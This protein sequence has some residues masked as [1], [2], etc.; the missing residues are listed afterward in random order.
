MALGREPLDRPR[1]VA[2][3]LAVAGMV[4]VVA[5][6]LDPAAGIRVDA[7]GFGLALAAAMSQAGFVVISRTGYRAVPA[8]QAM[9]VV[10]ATTLVC[11]VVLARRHRAAGATLTYPLRDPS[12]LP[13]LAVHRTVR[14]AIPS[15]L[16]LT[17]IRL[18]GGTRAG[19]L[20]LFEPVVGVALAA[21]LL[22]E[23]LAPIQV[24]GGL[25]ILAAAVIL[26]RS[27]APGGADGAAPAI[28]ADETATRRRRSGC[29]R[30]RGARG[31]DG[32]PEPT[33]AGDGSLAV[34]ARIRVLIVDDHAMVRRGMRDFLDLHDDLEVVGEAP[35]GAGRARGRAPRSHPDVVVMDL[36]MPGLDGI[37]A[38]AEM[39]SAPPGRGGRRA[40][41]ASSRRT[42]SRPH[43]GR[44]RAGSSSR[45]PRRTTWPAPSAPRTPARSTS[46][47]PWPASSPRRMRSGGRRDGGSG[48]AEAALDGA[49]GA[50]A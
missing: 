15:I 38:T 34:G 19:I 30:R 12:V 24:A 45:T 37:A 39:K 20:M 10:L 13:L 22:D 35:D 26:Q 11:A 5:S 4:A 28:E 46:T 23:R 18:I 29:R 7:I 9:A 41:R 40:S 49:D 48:T 36:V 2:L 3:G 47:R 17:G 14:G 25:A 6:Q 27:A 42:A 43:R 8:S 50:R 31:D 32:A 1:V 33:A 44:R 16:F 21:V